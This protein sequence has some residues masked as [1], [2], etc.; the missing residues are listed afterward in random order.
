MIVCMSRRIA[1][2]MYEEITKLRPQWHNTEKR[3]GTIKVVMTSSSSDPENWQMH[4][5][6]KDDRKEIA[7]R[8][9]TPEDSLKIVIV[10]DMWLTGLMF[11]VCIR[12]M[13]IS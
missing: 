13:L 12:C 4:N 8:F 10:C 7:E 1:V 5:T 6:S 3:K 2:A 11:L 9:K